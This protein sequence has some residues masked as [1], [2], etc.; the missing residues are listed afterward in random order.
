MK[1]DWRE[2]KKIYEAPV[3]P[4]TIWNDG[5]RKNKGLEEGRQREGERWIESLRE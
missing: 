3:T 2:K 5:R 4:V 1:S